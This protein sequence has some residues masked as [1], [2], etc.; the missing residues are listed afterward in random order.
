PGGV[1]VWVLRNEPAR[2]L[3]GIPVGL[4]LAD[5]EGDLVLKVG[6]A[7]GGGVV[8]VDWVPDQVG[9]E[10]DGVLVEGFGL[11]GDAAVGIAPP[12]GGHRLAGGA[13]H[14]LPPAGDVVPGVYLHQLGADAL[15]QGDGDRVP[16]GSV[17]AGHDVALL[18]LVGVGL[19]PGVVLAG[20]VVGGIDLG[21]GVLQLGGE[22]GAVAVA[23]GVGPPLL[24]DLQG[25]GH[26]VQV[27]GDGDAP[28]FVGILH[29]FTP[30]NHLSLYGSL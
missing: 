14:H 5:V 13:V 8:H 28:F 24:Q 27:G 21:A 23:D 3:H 16:P 26:H 29:T 12:G 4:G 2:P 20:G 30:C 15:H 6:P 22:L 10:A 7:V 9:Q 25:L 19:G 18:D 1:D 17:E 11:D